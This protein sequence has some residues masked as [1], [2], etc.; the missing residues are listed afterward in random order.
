LKN[1]AGKS[2]SAQGRLITAENA[3][4]GERQSAR[5]SG[6]GAVPFLTAGPGEAH[7]T[8]G[9]S[10]ADAVTFQM[11]R[12]TIVVRAVRPEDQAG[13]TTTPETR[14]RQDRLGHLIDAV[15]RSA[16][17]IR[18]QQGRREAQAVTRPAARRA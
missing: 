17:S 4:S 2:S 12:M 11:I 10:R 6:C 16:D 9:T 14:P 13:T 3:G 15:E 5:K 8:S 1:Q 18:P 7:A